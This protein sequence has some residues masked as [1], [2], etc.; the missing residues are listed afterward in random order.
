[1]QRISDLTL[2]FIALTILIPIL[3]P[4]MIL[5]KFTGEGD[6]FYSQQRVGKNGTTFNLLK[7]ATML[8][9]SPQLGSGTVTVKD[10]PRVLPIGKI[11]RK[12]KINELPQLINVIRG[13]MSLIGPRPLTMQTFDAYNL[14]TKN[15]VKSVVPGLSGIGSIVFR[16]EE[17]ILNDAEDVKILY[18]NLIAPYKGELEV[19]YVKNKSFKLYL[20]LILMTIYVVLFSRRNK[21][22]SLFPTL[23]KPSEELLKKFNNFK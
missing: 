5:L 4:V 16:D 9:N 8:R 6:I 14:E 13:D 18:K 7:F 23:P 1:M 2:S 15:I 17:Q 21:L 22:W 3:V 10:D 19:W 12:T 11:L 20:Y